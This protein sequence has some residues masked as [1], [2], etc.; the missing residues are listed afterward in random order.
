MINNFGFG[1]FEGFFTLL[2]ILVNFLE[3]WSIWLLIFKFSVNHFGA[4]CSIPLFFI[5]FIS[6]EIDFSLI[7]IIL[8]S[9]IIIFMTFVYNFKILWSR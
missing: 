9:I 4:I 1:Q 5:C 7:M 8:G 2:S 6:E 3:M